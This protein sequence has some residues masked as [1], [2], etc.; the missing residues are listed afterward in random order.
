MTVFDAAYAEAY[1]LVYADK[2]YAGEAA[3][4]T[5]LLRDAV[6]LARTLLEFGSGTG[7]HARL[8]AEAGYR[9][10]G[11][12]PSRA[13]LAVARAAAADNCT[14]AAGDMR[15]VSTGE[16]YDAAIALFHVVG[17]LGSNDDLDQAF[18]NARTQIVDGGVFIFDYWY[19]P[20]VLSDPPTVRVKRVS[21]DRLEVT[22][23]AEPAMLVNENAVE[24]AYHIWV[25]N[26][27]TGLVTEHDERHRVRYMF[28]PEIERIASANG[29][30]VERS[31]HWMTGR[32]LGA[33][34]WYGVSVA[35]AV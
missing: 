28:L 1:D 35:R 5:R 21:G 20:A 11:I 30:R 19:G 9:V 6:P 2:D 25:R 18:A 22:R 33:D 24:V 14:F 12:E 8:L 29:F 15:T 10:H 16:R 4:M 17:Y 34:T 26:R 27:A 7:R 32:T 13:M 3:Y 31:E 23:L